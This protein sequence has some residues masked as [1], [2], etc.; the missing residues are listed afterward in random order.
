MGQ[1]VAFSGKK[2]SGATENVQT[3]V[4]QHVNKRNCNEQKDKNG[5]ELFHDSASAFWVNTQASSG[6]CKNVRL[7]RKFRR[8]DGRVARLAHVRK[9]RGRECPWANRTVLSKNVRE[10]DAGS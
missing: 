8:A 7:K 4:E 9:H 10:A 2:R 1:A 3:Y 5:K 6:S